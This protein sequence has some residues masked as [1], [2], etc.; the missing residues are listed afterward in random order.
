M[1]KMVRLVLAV[2]M[3][4]GGVMLAG[5]AWADCDPACPDGEVCRYEASNGEYYCK[6]PPVRADNKEA[7]GSRRDAGSKQPVATT[8]G[9]LQ[10][11]QIQQE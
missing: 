6:A 10:P 11:K 2:T 7:L 9:N 8:P 3:V 5:P 1:K 4:N